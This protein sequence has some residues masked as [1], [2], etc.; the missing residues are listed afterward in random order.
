[1]ENFW[2]DVYFETSER[3]VQTADDNSKLTLKAF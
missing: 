3:S 2:V 1:M